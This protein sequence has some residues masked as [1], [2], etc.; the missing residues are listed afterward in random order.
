MRG[1]SGCCTTT[2]GKS[3]GLSWRTR[4]PQRTST[5]WACDSGEPFSSQRAKGRRAPGNGPR[6]RGGARIDRRGCRVRPPRRP[7]RR[8]PRAVGAGTGAGGSGRRGR[9]RRAPAAATEH[10]RSRRVRAGVRTVVIAIEIP[11]AMCRAMTWPREQRKTA[12]FLAP[13]P[14]LASAGRASFG[15]ESGLGG[16]FMKRARDGRGARDATGPA[17]RPEARMP[18]AATSSST[19]SSSSHPPAGAARGRSTGSRP[20]RG[21][22]GSS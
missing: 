15:A 7:R 19:S 9:A 17:L 20:S 3:T 11:L 12:D 1:R 16:L 6:S 4:R 21:G 8:G 10:A 14:V 13:G 5:R 2:S 22:T 18:D